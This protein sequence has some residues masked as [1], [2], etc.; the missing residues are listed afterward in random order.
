MPES[1]LS[2]ENKP[3]KS[4]EL[5]QR[6]QRLGATK[7]RSYTPKPRGRTPEQRPRADEANVPFEELDGGQVQ[8][9]ATGEYYLYSQA[10]PAGE[11]HGNDSLADWNALLPETLARIGN[12]PELADYEPKQFV[13]VDIE[14]TGLGGAGTI[15][16]L[17]GV[18]WFDDGGIFH[19]NQYFLRDPAE[20][21]SSLTALSELIDSDTAL[22]TFNGRTFD[23]P[24]LSDR[25]IIN[26]KPSLLASLPNLDLLHPAR[27]LWRRRLRSCS[28]GSL[29]Q[30]IL[31]VERT[32]ED[33]P[34]WMIPAL[35][36]QFLQTGNGYHM[37]RVVYHNRLDMLSMV[38]LGVQMSRIFEQPHNGELHT[39]DHISLA[40]WYQKQEDMSEETEIAYRTALKNASSETEEYDALYGLAMLLKRSGR[41]DE[42]LAFW[43]RLASLQIDV[44]GHVELAKYFEW[45]GDNLDAALQWT[46]QAIHLLEQ[47]SNNLHNQQGLSSLYHR[48]RRLIRK[49]ND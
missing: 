16:F 33:V 45:Y 7:N 42:A 13:F 31:G 6:L 24:I 8:Q 39:D 5:R 3:S 1:N 11:V 21:I 26:R 18:G 44:V 23:I 48:Q 17:V 43:A 46:E 20:E 4:V 37:K 9:T 29:E 2:P 40:R 35:Y 32:G 30:N 34:G 22:V 10:Y 19:L 38:T 12:L 49:L 41:G 47:S 27:R 14:T 28:L 15:P 25:F 36:N